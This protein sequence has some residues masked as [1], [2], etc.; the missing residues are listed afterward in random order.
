MSQ[1]DGSLF[2]KDQPCFGCGPEHPFGFHLAFRQEGDE[3]I[4]RF[5]PA[6]KYQGAPGIMHGGLV[7]TLA[8]ELAAWVLI[9]RL[10]KFGFTTRFAGKLQNPTRLGVELEGRASILRSTT[11]TAEIE[12]RLTQQ[13]KDVF[14][15]TFTFVLLDKG[16]AEKLLGRSLPAEWARF[17]R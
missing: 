17:A 6:D 12:T 13:G 3:V 11:R 9:A 5:T 16:A 14:V 2:G 15:G 1:L 8:D 7:F 4:T 10:G